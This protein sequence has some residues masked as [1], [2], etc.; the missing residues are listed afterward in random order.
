MIIQNLNIDYLN[1][2]IDL[3][4]VI[5]TYLDNKDQLE[6]LSVKEFKVVL[7]QGYA[8]GVIK[9]G[10]LIAFRA[11]LI[12][13][14]NDPDHLAYD[15]N[16]PVDRSIYSEVS[17]VH[18]H[19][20]GKGLQTKMGKYLLEKVIESKKFKYVF[21][22]VDPSN[23]ASMYDKFKLGFVIVNTKYKYEHKLRHVF[24]K[25]LVNSNSTGKSYITYVPHSDIG[26]MLKNRKNFIGVGLR[27]RDIMYIRKNHT[28]GV[29][30]EVL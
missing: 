11:F 13:H 27:N 9:S 23:V 24:V 18:P 6:T 29:K 8:V 2:V 21:A 25:D 19:Y 15:A 28:E 20:R 17:F 26:W 7:S 3:Q 30:N 1:A 4:T 10:Q 14:D 22:T 12:P 16:L 5:Y